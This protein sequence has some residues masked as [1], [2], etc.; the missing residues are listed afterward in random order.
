MTTIE[1][2]VHTKLSL[3]FDLIGNDVLLKFKNDMV[4]TCNSRGVQVPLLE[5]NCNNKN[6][7]TLHVNVPGDKKFALLHS[8]KPIKNPGKG[9]YNRKGKLKPLPKFHVSWLLLSSVSYEI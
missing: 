6:Y 2:T 5:D 3:S 8:W 7:P 1:N 4:V 9:K